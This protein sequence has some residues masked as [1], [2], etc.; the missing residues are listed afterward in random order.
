MVTQSEKINF[1]RKYFGSPSVDRTGENIA[2]SCPSCKSQSGKKKFSINLN[3]WQSHCWVCGLKGK[4][5]LP[6]LRKFCSLESAREFE[7][8]FI[9]KS[10]YANQ[11][12][13]EEV[14]TVKIPENFIF[15][16]D[17]VKGSDPDVNACLRYLHSRGISERD[18]WYYKMGTV[19]RGKFRRS[20]IIP[21]FDESGDLNYFVTRKIDPDSRI[22]YVNAKADKKKIIFN[23]ININ[24]S[25][26]LTIVEGPFDLVKC[27]DN[28]TCL[29]GSSLTEQMLLFRKIVSHKT[30]VL[31]A[32][33]SDMRKKSLKIAKL[34]ASYDCEVRL[35]SLGDKSDV[36]EMTREEFEKARSMAKS[37]NRETSLRS[38]IAEISSGSLI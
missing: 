21:S 12:D 24:W 23:D 3:T 34:L 20:I 5:L 22:K 36:G 15:L 19:K 25:Q 7:K 35:L 27:N 31:L 28:A 2:V 13:Q 16:V 38:R 8:K 4:T 10:T 26:E 30:P 6:I 1:I 14:D 33:D 37:W 29:L 11:E 32:L 17:N 18:L 9:G